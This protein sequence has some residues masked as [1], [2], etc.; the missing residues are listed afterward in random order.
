M[1]IL[2]HI[3][4]KALTHCLFSRQFHVISVTLIDVVFDTDDRFK[5][6][7]GSGVPLRR[8]VNIIISLRRSGDQI[9][10]FYL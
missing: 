7:N 9:S 6:G 4:K 2:V 10:H 1:M 5:G 8:I 3:R